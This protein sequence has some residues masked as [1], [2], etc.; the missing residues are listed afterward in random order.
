MDP[1]VKAIQEKVCSVCID[2]KY[3]G[4]CSLTMIQTCAAE[5]YLP[6]IVSA[7]RKVS[8]RKIEDYI[9]Q[10]RE[11]VCSSCRYESPDGKCALRETL[12][13]GLDRYYPL[14][15]QAVESIDSVKAGK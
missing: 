9:E 2:R 11:D 6:R 13:C 15:V 5:L 3:D 8:S 7:I 14:I 1:Y 12:D 10:L 4:T